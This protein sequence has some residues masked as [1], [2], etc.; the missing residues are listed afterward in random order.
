MRLLAILLD[1]VVLACAIVLSVVFRDE[2]I[3]LVFPAATNYHVSEFELGAEQKHVIVD[4]G[5]YIAV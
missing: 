1:L 4:I 2:K 3:P 5:I